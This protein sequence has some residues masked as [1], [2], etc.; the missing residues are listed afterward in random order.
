MSIKSVD[1]L[2]ARVENNKMGVEQAPLP[3]IEVS[4]PVEPESTEESSHDNVPHE[5]TEDD[6]PEESKHAEEIAPESEPEKPVKPAKEAKESAIDEYGNPIAK[7]KT[8]NEEDVQRMI[9]ERLARSRPN[10][11]AIQPNIQK[12]V[13][14]FEADP[15]SDES[16]DVQLKNFVKQTLQ[17]TQRE[18]SENRWRQEEAQR[19]ADFESKFT[20][21]MDKYSDFH[22]VVKG[23]P[24]TD[25]MMMAARNLDNPAAFIYGAAK[26]HPQELARIASIS[27]PYAQASEIG[28]LHEKMVKTRAAVSNAPKPIEPPKGVLPN[29][30]INQPSLE[31]RIHQY[32]KQKRK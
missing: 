29:K 5:T 11:Q 16:W 25:T 32:A 1:D 10:E 20:T 28:R 23:K 13:D 27:D 17:E 15:N 22:Q 9:R 31:D 19:Q 7:S 24:I 4:A 14:N 6:A 26:L 18:E 12:K 2:I 3:P 30:A 8:Y 21:G